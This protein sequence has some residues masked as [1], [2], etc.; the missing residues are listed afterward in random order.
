MFYNSELL[1]LQR[2]LGKCNLRHMILNPKSPLT[3]HVDD[4]IRRIFG[5]EY[6][7]T[8]YD[9]FPD[10]K[11]K[12]IYRVSDYYFCNYVFFVLPFHGEKRI[13]LTGP[14]LRQDITAESVLELCEE[15]NIPPALHKEVEYFYASMPVVTEELHINAMINTFAEF[16][17]GGE[18][19]YEWQDVRGEEH[20]LFTSPQ[21][22]ESE[23]ANVSV[24]ERRYEFEN[25]LMD[26]VSQ[27]NTHKAEDMMSTFS[28]LAFESRVPDRLRN[29]KNYCIIMNTLLRKAAEKGGVHPVYLNRISSD[30]A[31]RIE[32]LHTVA[33]VSAFMT[34]ILRSYCKLVRRHSIKDYSPPIQKAIILI[35]SDLTRDL[36]L[37]ALA[38]LCGVSKGYFSALFK[39]ETGKT[40]TEFVN[41][42]RI[43]HAKHLLTDTSLQIQTVA[44]HCGILDLNDFCRLFKSITGKTPTEYRAHK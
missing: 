27:G 36:G 31:H 28:S 39:R 43:A 24:M 13:F 20:S 30:F 22:T 1:F 14:Y 7:K 38:Q 2:M 3:Q 42:K 29:M 23:T 26:A 16:V 25:E 40:L 11:E 6:R 41:K 18:D 21:A 8:F 4:S 19:S 9:Y 17:F 15:L 44:Q 33:A 10:I 32:N 37:S 5:G 12:V 34:E 35:D